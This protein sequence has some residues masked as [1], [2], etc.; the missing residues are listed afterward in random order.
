MEQL[1][2]KWA[3]NQNGVM[4]GRLHL[5]QIQVLV[6]GSERILV[7]REDGVETVNLRLPEVMAGRIGRLLLPG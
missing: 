4:Y 6:V 2:P 1:L 3:E 7:I 5:T